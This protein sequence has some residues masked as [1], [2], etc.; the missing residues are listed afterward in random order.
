MGIPPKINL[1][2][3]SMADSIGC[4]AFFAAVV[5]FASLRE[6][7]N[8]GFANP[9]GVSPSSSLSRAS[10]AAICLLAFD[11]AVFVSSAALAAVALAV[12]ICVNAL[13]VELHDA[14]REPREVDLLDRN[15][16]PVRLM[17]DFPAF[18]REEGSV[19]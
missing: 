19:P 11:S 8:P 4:G 15:S 2:M 12:S 1:L 16:D 18:R 9:R 17:R 7:T 10:S 5:T 13:S 6:A 14:M 3:V